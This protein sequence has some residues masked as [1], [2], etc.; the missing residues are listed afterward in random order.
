MVVIAADALNRLRH[1]DKMVLL[2]RL[3]NTVHHHHFIFQILLDMAG[4]VP[5]QQ[6]TDAALR[7]ILNIYCLIPAAIYLIMTAFMLLWKLDEGR[8][9][10][11][12]AELEVRRRLETND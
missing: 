11:I 3:Q 2:Q 4:Y 10:E 7:G 6:Q 1:Q 9:H 8:M 12:V 5:N